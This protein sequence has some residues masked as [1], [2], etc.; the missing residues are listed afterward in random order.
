LESFLDDG[1][2]IDVE[3]VR[4]SDLQSTT[5]GLHSRVGA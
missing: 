4:G 5:L 1:A 2:E 3:F